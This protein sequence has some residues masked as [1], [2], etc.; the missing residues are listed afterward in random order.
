MA[1][2]RAQKRQREELRQRARSVK[3]SACPAL[4]LSRDFYRRMF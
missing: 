3:K 2:K 4:E 1:Q